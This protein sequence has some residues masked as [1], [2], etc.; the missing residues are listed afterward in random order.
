MLA[1][2]KF[3]TSHKEVLFSHLSDPSITTSLPDFKASDL[4]LWTSHI[5]DDPHSYAIELDGVMI[6]ACRLEQNEYSDFS[7]WISA[8]H[9]G[10]GYATE[11]NRKLCRMAISLGWKTLSCH[12]DPTNTASQTVLIRCG[13]TQVSDTRWT[14]SL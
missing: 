1:L 4:D 14:K 13:F 10:R 12:V 8:E 9:R 7:Y 3:R 2:T 5:L 6:G 11:I